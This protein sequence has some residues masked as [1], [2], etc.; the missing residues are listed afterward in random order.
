MA[1]SPSFRQPVS[2]NIQA[3]EQRLVPSGASDG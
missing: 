3:G 1:S 2:N